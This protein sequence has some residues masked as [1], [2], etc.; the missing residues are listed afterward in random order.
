MGRLSDRLT[1]CPNRFA[2][3]TFNCKTVLLVEIRLYNLKK[4]Q[5]IIIEIR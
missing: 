2:K 3:E 5:K 1:V 4:W